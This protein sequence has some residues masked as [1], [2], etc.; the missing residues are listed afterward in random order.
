M[1][2]D[3][4]NGPLIPFYIFMVLEPPPPPP[5]LPPNP[6]TPDTLSVGL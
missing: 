2:T 5:P 3:F 1:Y 6:L 4:Q